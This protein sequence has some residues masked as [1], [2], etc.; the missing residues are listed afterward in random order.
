MQFSRFIIVSHFVVSYGENNTT[1]GDTSGKIGYLNKQQMAVTNRHASPFN[2]VPWNPR[3]VPVWFW[4]FNTSG[5]II[6]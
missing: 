4:L 3:A 2:Q 1:R 6:P 5:S